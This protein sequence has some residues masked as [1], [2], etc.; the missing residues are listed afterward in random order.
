MRCVDM[1][2]LDHRSADVPSN[3]DMA[4]FVV[5]RHSHSQ[6]VWTHGLQARLPAPRLFESIQRGEK[7]VA[8]RSRNPYRVV[9]RLKTSGDQSDSEL[10]VAEPVD[11]GA[12]VALEFQ[13]RFGVRH[14][15][16]HIDGFSLRL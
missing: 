7:L 4:R 5:C 13:A 3:D 2:V 8:R 10:H 11:R 6:V 12:G 15:E 14:E 1:I 9:S 16:A